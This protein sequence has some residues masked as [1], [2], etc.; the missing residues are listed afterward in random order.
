MLRCRI[1]AAYF[2]RFSGILKASHERKVDQMATEKI[3][4]Q[5]I[6]CSVSSCRYNDGCAYCS[7]SRIEVQPCSGCKNH[8][9]KPAD[10][11]LCGSYRTR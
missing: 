6:A 2:L 9:G 10:E 5:T 7:L 4:N 3:G 8:T 1:P 11:S